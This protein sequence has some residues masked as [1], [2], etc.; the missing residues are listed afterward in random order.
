MPLKSARLLPF[1]LLELICLL[2][3]LGIVDAATD[4]D[5]AV[6]SGGGDASPFDE[7][8]DSLCVFTLE[9]FFISTS[10]MLGL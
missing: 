3:R 2:C 9:P 10:R 7:P 8:P 4:D 5:D 6:D 1:S